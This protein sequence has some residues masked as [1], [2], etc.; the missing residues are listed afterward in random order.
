MQKDSS[1]TKAHWSCNVGAMPSAQGLPVM[2]DMHLISGNFAWSDDSPV[3]FSLSAL[4]HTDALFR[5]II[6][7]ICMNYNAISDYYIYSTFLVKNS[8]FV[9]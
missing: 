9:L 2:S 4:C 5:H 3:L 7:A 1:R 6:T 8:F